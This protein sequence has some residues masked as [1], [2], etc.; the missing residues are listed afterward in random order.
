ML[1]NKEDSSS[2]TILFLRSNYLGE[3]LEFQTL[4]SPD[5]LSPLKSDW[6]AVSPGK[7]RPF[8]RKS[9]RVTSKTKSASRRLLLAFTSRNVKLTQ[10]F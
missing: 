9:T 6:A 8:Y 5:T 10:K 2:S 7:V 3:E 1:R 4:C